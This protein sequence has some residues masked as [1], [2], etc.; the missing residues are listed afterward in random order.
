M[1]L[2]TPSTRREVQRVYEKERRLL[3]EH[4]VLEDGREGA[5]AR[6]VFLGSGEGP[7][8]SAD[9]GDPGGAR[10]HGCGNGDE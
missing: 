3:T 6:T 2:V 5:L 4:A 7:T 8:Q 1:E 9:A 10:Y